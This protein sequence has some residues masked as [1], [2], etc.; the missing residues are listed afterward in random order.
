MIGRSMIAACLALTLCSGG[1]WAQTAAPAAPA[2][3]PAGTMAPTGKM[4]P[5]G[6]MAKPRTAQSIACSSKA[7]AQGLHGKPRKGFMKTCKAGKA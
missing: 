6:K 1:A 7:D 3:A 4:A 2:A 5:A